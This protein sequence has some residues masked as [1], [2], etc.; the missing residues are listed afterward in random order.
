MME[1]VARA[2]E[3]AAGLRPSKQA[4]L[5]KLIGWMV[6]PSFIGPKPFGKNMP[7]GPDFVIRDE[8]DFASTKARLTRLLEDF[9]AKGERGC[10]G[11]IH[12]FFG[13]LAGAEWGITQFKHMDHHLRQFGV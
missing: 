8:P 9:H 3:V 6:R 7:T 2:L 10:D 1:H 13:K 5:G 11:N 12:G 4:L